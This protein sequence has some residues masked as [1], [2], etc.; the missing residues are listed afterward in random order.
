MAG[1]MKNLRV[2]AEVL[3]KLTKKHH[4]TVTEVEHAFS[5]RS[6]GLLFDTRE[7]HKTDPPTLWFIAC[8]NKGRLLKVVYIQ[9]GSEVHLKS[10]F[11]PNA[12]EIRIYDKYA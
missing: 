2:S 10:A 3:E 1:K 7:E 8:T 12:D 5:N 4:V 9:I 6:K 11:E